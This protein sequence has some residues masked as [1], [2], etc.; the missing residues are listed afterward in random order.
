MIADVLPVPITVHV[1]RRPCRGTQLPSPLLNPAAA[2]SGGS[3]A[4]AQA[5]DWVGMKHRTVIVGSTRAHVRGG[6]APVEALVAHRLVA[7]LPAP[8]AET[9]AR[10]RRVAAAVAAA[11]G[12]ASRAA[13]ASLVSLLRMAHV[14]A[15]EPAARQVGRGQGKVVWGGSLTHTHTQRGSRHAAGH[16]RRTSHSQSP[17]RSEPTPVTPVRKPARSHWN[18]PWQHHRRPV[19]TSPTTPESTS[20]SSSRPISRWLPSRHSNA[21]LRGNPC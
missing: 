2:A 20:P 4:A 8:P 18:G 17:G 11:V 1:A 13:R 19:R 9:R 6:A 16:V 5:G 10:V 21:V 15:H 7:L 3:T 12:V 14:G